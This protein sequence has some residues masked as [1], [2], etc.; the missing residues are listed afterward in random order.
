MSRTCA[1]LQGTTPRETLPVIR[2]IYAENQN[3]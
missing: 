3:R 2:K 1:K